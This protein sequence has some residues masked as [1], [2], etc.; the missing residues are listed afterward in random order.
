MGDKKISKKKEPDLDYGR[1]GNRGEDLPGVVE[2]RES[3]AKQP[4]KEIALRTYFWG[5]N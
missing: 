4:E 1:K 5:L 3:Q 2:G